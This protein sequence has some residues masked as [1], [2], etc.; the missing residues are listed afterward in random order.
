MESELVSA[1]DIHLLDDP[2]EFNPEH[3]GKTAHGNTIEIKMSIL[4][5]ADKENIK[6]ECAKS[7]ARER[8]CVDNY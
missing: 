5:D 3:F 1:T 2:P 7:K 6:K 8:S 4:H